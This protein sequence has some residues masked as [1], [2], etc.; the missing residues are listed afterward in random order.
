MGP[1]DGHCT[2]SPD[3]KWILC[4]TYP[5]RQRN[6]HLYLYHVAENRRVD[7]GSFFQPPEYW[8]DPHFREWRC[9]LHPRFT[10]D[11]RHVVV[12]SPHAGGRQLY[13]VD[14]SGVVG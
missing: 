13:V 7:V 9:D 11:G 3:L 10:P 12:D 14:V 1:G 4:D 6:I 8:S 5:D 2:Y